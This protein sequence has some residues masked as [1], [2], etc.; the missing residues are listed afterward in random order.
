MSGGS[1]RCD[2]VELEG[3]GELLEELDLG[4]Y[5][6]LSLLTEVDIKVTSQEYELPLFGQ[7]YVL[8]GL[9]QMW[10]VAHNSLVEVDRG[11]PE[12]LQL[13]QDHSM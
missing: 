12:Y 13:A 10:D 2:D 11:Q 9:E 5:W 3:L 6:S 1:T 7:D 4:W 8:N